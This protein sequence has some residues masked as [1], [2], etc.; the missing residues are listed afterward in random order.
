MA[1]PNNGVWVHTDFGRHADRRHASEN[2]QYLHSRPFFNREHDVNSLLNVSAGVMVLSAVAVRRMM[3]FSSVAS[4]CEERGL[5]NP[6]GS[7]SAGTNFEIT[8]TIVPAGTISAC[9][10]LK[11]YLDSRDRLAPFELGSVGPDTMHDDS[12]LPS[13]GNFCLFCTDSLGEL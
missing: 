11:I 5:G 1:I 7:L 13:D 2:F 8:D 6:G 3:V 12:Q 4:Q 9:A 10:E